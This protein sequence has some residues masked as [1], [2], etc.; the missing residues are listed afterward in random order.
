MK[1]TY[2]SIS[3]TVLSLTFAAFCLAPSQSACSRAAET[4]APPVE[5][6][7]FVQIDRNGDGKIVLEEFQT[8]FPNMNE[9][10]F[11]V[12]DRNKDQG[13]DRIEWL[14]FMENHGK[15]RPAPD[16]APVM[17]NIPGDPLI[18]PVD[19]SDLPLMRPPQ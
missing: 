15:S 6:D 5:Q 11:V 13:I 1:K 14:E 17:N 19:S 9:Q 18:P 3:R 7:R 4:Q 16:H 8:A 10:A 2:L 12:I